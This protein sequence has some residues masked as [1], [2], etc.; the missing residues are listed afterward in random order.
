MSVHL[1]REPVTLSKRDRETMLV[2]AEAPYCRNA[3]HL[4]RTIE[5]S[6]GRA[7]FTHGREVKFATDPTARFIARRYQ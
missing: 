4:N 1:E 3:I 6:D 5:A 2:Q 7:W